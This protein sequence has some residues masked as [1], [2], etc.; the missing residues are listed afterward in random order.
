MKTT[1]P[2]SVHFVVRPSVPLVV[3]EIRGRK[4]IG[5]CVVTEFLLVL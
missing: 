4:A 1:K 2:A 5:H 3:R